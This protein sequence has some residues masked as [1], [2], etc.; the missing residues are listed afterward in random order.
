MYI[1]FATSDIKHVLFILK[2]FA[3]FFSSKFE[4]YIFDQY[5]GLEII[6]N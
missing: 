1:I 2:Y 6:D 4:K 3:Y 5:L